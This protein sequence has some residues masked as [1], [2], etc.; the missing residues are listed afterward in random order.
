MSHPSHIH[1]A[2]LFTPIALVLA[3]S[4]SP[5][6]EPG[7]DGPTLDS[8][9]T[10]DSSSTVDSE[11]S[12]EP[13]WEDA[14]PIIQ[15]RCSRCHSAHRLSTYKRL[16]THEDVT[17]L[18]SNI[19]DKLKTEPPR[20]RRM[21]VASNHEGGCTPAHPAINDKR[22][23]EDELEILRAFLS[24]T[25]HLD[26]VDTLAPLSPPEVPELADSVAYTSTEFEVLNDGFLEHPDGRSEEYME[27]Y[28]YDQREYD[29]MED[30]WFCIRFNPD[31][32]E[33]GYLTGVQAETRSGQIHLNAQLVI[34]TTGASAAA[35]SAAEERGTDW[36]R[37]DAGLGFSDS[38][39]LWRTVPGGEAV[40]L[41]EG[42][43]LRF[44]PGWTFVLR[45]DFHTHFDAE[46]FNALEQ[47]GVIDYDAGTMTWFNDAT[48]RAR[49]ADPEDISR[50]LQWTSVGPGS[51]EE[52]E[53]FEVA[54]GESSLRYSADL[55]GQAER[56]T[57]FSAELG[58]G[59]N[60]T[61]ASLVDSGTSTCVANNGDFHPKWIEQ[62]VYAEGD[63]PEL[64][65][66]ATLELTCDYRS[67]QEES[68]GWGSESE[69]T[70]WGRQERCAAVVFFYES[71]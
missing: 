9:S 20:G 66:D 53:A 23:T 68:V 11:A 45:A 26:Y 71:L 41:P 38:I 29:Q 58:M 27:D 13:D 34:D 54:P 44:E 8:P 21:P 43:G 59:Y 31:R 7:D 60:G 61:T 42:T 49:W 1:P 67:E 56:Y 55:P 28:G 47:D 39:P 16:E 52:R 2:F 25:D 33:A 6:T 17:Q 14:R 30:D 36:Y 63:A 57:V 48:V 50:E 35:Q 18:R 37:C 4:R 46:E 10:V 62:T 24:R 64:A 70:V 32:N 40:E 69:A 19:L 3:C 12:G 22:V 15:A 51:A 5:A 65:G